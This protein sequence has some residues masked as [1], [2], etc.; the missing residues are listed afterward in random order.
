MVPS[1][2]G[3][4]FPGKKF[5][6]NCSAHI[7]KNPQGPEGRGFRGPG[8]GGYLVGYARLTKEK[9][10]E[11]VVIRSEGTS[12]LHSSTVIAPNHSAFP[13]SL[14]SSQGYVLQLIPRLASRPHRFLPSGV[15]A[16]SAT[17]PSSFRFPL[18]IHLSRN[19]KVHSK[20]Q[21]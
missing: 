7:A 5:A 15:R 3:P 18:K 21:P 19:Q 1:F 4:K 14:A 13:V 2:L 10:P 20:V 17:P 12:L 8:S 6:S 16:R 9:P 11:S